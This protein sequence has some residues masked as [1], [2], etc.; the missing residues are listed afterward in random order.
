MLWHV[1][2]CELT[3]VLDFFGSGACFLQARAKLKA[4]LE[5][6]LESNQVLRMN[7]GTA[8]KKA[9]AKAKKQAA[10]EITVNAGLST[11]SN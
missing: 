8:S 1:Y 7:A 11:L 4:A 2:S 10:A 5:R 6:E 9:H 3:Q